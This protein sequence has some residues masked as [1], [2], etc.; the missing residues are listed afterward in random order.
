[1]AGGL[2]GTARVFYVVAGAVI[3]GVWALTLKL[4]GGRKLRRIVLP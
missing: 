3:L 4:A 2:G 1:V